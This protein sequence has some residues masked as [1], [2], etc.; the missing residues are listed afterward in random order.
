MQLFALQA[1]AGTGRPYEYGPPLSTRADSPH[2]E[3]LITFVS[4]GAAVVR[5]ARSVLFDRRRAK[6]Q[7]SRR[8]AFVLY[9]HSTVQMLS[10][11]T[12]L[13]LSWGN[14]TYAVIFSVMP[15]G[16]LGLAMERAGG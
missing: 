14:V 3:R 2:R 15:E 8:S 7:L 13:T 10:G 4:K 5:N 6:L 11:I 12:Y 1:D 9:L 16:K